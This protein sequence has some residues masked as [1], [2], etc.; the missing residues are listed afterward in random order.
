MA[1]TPWANPDRSISARVM[2]PLFGMMGRVSTASPKLLTTDRSMRSTSVSW[3]PA[4]SASASTSRSPAWG[5]SSYRCN[6]CSTSAIW[7]CSSA[8][9]TRDQPRLFRAAEQVSPVQPKSPDRGLSGIASHG[10]AVKASQKRTDLFYVKSKRCVEFFFRHEEL[11]A[12]IRGALPPTHVHARR[13][14]RLS[15]AG[16][17]PAEPASVSA[18]WAKLQLIDQLVVIGRSS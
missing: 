14:S 9:S 7:R 6:R 13:S 17:S 15:L 5:S 12:C 3:S 4:P 10:F 16:C 1:Y 11:Q 18:R 2:P 8:S